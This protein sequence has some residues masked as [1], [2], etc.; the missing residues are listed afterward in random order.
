MRNSIEQHTFPHLIKNFL[1]VGRAH[2]FS[3]VS[4]SRVGEEELPLSSNSSINILLSI[5][6]LL[7]S[8]NHTDVTWMQNIG[9]S[10]KGWDLQQ[11]ELTQ[12]IL[13]LP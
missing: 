6:V 2:A 7:A 4:V 11:E 13:G 3:Q 12:V 9:L 10:L 8:V 1:E 5:D